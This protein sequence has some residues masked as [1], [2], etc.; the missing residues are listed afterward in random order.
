MIDVTP[1]EDPHRLTTGM[2]GSA[3]IEVDTFAI[4]QAVNSQLATTPA[5]L[6]QQQAQIEEGLW[7]KVREMAAHVPL[8][9]DVVAMYYALLDDRTPWETKATIA[10]VLLYIISPIDLVP[11]AALGPIGYTDE[12]ALIWWAVNNL[13]ADLK[14]EHYAA[15]R[16]ALRAPSQFPPPTEDEVGRR[17]VSGDSAP[18][19]E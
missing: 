17:R 13:A 8:V 4:Q 10:A 5:E 19:I 6:A 12:A 1:V 7:P 2:P 18:Q 9:P 15:A 16:Q 3:G 14:P 11:E